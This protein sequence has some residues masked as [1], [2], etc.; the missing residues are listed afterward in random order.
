[1]FD[2]N[3]LHNCVGLWSACSNCKNCNVTA[4]KTK[5]ILNTEW[6]HNVNDNCSQLLMHINTP[7]TVPVVIMANNAHRL[8][9]LCVWSCSKSTGLQQSYGV[10]RC[11]LGVIRYRVHMKNA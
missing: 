9:L 6:K 4:G 1:M 10:T 8:I 11:V 3:T 7:V 5:H 2:V